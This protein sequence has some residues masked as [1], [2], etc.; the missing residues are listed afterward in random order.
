MD[1]VRDLDAIETLDFPVYAVGITPQGPLKNGPGE[2]NV[3]IC[4]GGRVVCPGD[5]IVGDR[6]GIVIIPQEDAGDILQAS[7]DKYELEQTR[8]RDNDAGDRSWVDKQL[9]KL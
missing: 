9:E 4:C 2:I 6:D 1:V 3:P 5:I 7:I 8:I